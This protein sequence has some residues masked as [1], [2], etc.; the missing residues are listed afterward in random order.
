VKGLLGQGLLGFGAIAT[1]SIPLNPAR[2]DDSNS[3]E[4]HVKASQP[5]K[6]RPKM[7]LLGERLGGALYFEVWCYCNVL[8]TIGTGLK[9]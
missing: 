4:H 9:K 7:E 8:F 3:V 1:C 5:M 2:L 6:L